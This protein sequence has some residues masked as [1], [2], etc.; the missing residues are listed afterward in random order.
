MYMQKNTNMVMLPIAGMVSTM[1]SRNLTDRFKKHNFN[2]ERK[3]EAPFTYKNIQYIHTYTYIHTYIQ[4]NKRNKRFKSW[5]QNDRHMC[6]YIYIHTY[7]HSYIHFI[8][9]IDTI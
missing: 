5:A 2:R 9:M 8:I 1:K 4:T 6:T 7:I 3:F